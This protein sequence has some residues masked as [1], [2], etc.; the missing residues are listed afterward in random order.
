MEVNIFWPLLLPTLDNPS[1]LLDET[2][3]MTIAPYLVASYTPMQLAFPPVPVM[4]KWMSDKFMD[5]L[6]SGPLTKKTFAHRQNTI[7]CSVRDFKAYFD[8][9][10][11]SQ[12]GKD[13]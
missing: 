1:T 3:A 2:L 8:R 7:Q 5:D 12:H 6:T 4:R 9:L 13:T 11:E 10:N